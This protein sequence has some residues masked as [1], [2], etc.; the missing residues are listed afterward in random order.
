MARLHRMDLTHPIVRDKAQQVCFL[1]VIV[2]VVSLALVLAPLQNFH[3]HRNFI[4]HT[5]PCHSTPLYYTSLHF[6]ALHCTTG[7]LGDH[8]PCVRRDI[9]VPLHR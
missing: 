2:L 6:T 4:T 5:V 1:I 9:C 7:V 8:P 3:S